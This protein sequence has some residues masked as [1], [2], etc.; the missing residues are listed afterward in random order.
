VQAGSRSGQKRTG[1]ST[2]AS[3]RYLKERVV[4]RLRR[5]WQWQ[6]QDGDQRQDGHVDMVNCERP[7]VP[8]L[9]R[10]LQR[11]RAPN[12]VKK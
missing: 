10:H 8:L 6:L 3:E 9:T 7:D 11:G 5:R 2:W 1:E 12:V 4:E